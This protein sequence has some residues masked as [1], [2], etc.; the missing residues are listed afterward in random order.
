MG[1]PTTL[2]LLYNINVGLS[3]TQASPFW[4]F[5]LQ[6]SPFRLNPLLLGFVPSG[7]LPLGFS[8]VFPFWAFPLQAS[9]FWAQTY[10]NQ[11]SVE[12]PMP[13]FYHLFIFK[14]YNFSQ[15]LKGVTSKIGPPRTI[16]FQNTY[17]GKQLIR[18]PC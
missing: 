16:Q 15:N 13:K 2:L 9:P 8:L 4:A 17:G 3:C 10:V 12:V 1:P 18:V 6:A 5:P 11:K 7:L 14:R